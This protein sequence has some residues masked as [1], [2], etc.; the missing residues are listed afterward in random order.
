MDKIPAPKNHAIIEILKRSGVR[1][2]F[3]L[4]ILSTL[5]APTPLLS[6]QDPP[7]KS[8]VKT[9]TPEEAYAKLTSTLEKRLLFWRDARKTDLTFEAQ[10]KLLDVRLADTTRYKNA[11]GDSRSYDQVKKEIETVK[12]T[13]ASHKKEHLDPLKEDYE[14]NIKTIKSTYDRFSPQTKKLVNPLIEKDLKRV[15]ETLKTITGQDPLSVARRETYQVFKKH[16]ED[17]A[18]DYIEIE[19]K[20]EPPAKK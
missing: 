5:I 4:G 10:L 1:V 20:T 6:Q 11:I 15:K 7:K 19:E 2:C 9:Y 14:R 16:L 18:K 8:G 17:L 13:R 12:A 3:V